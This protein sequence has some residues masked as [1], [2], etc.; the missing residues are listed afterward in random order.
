[1]KKILLILPLFVLLFSCNDLLD[2]A[3]TNIISED[4][5]K[6]DPVL[7]DAF[8]N[9]IYVNTRFQTRGNSNDYAPDQAILHVISGEANVFAAWQV[10]FAAAMKIIDEN[11]ANATS[12]NFV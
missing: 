6:N 3:P 8:L 10:P 9:K 2:I 5:V 1:M 7:V 12:Y 4:A 11:G